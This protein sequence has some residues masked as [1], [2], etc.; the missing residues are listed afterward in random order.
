MSGRAWQ[1]EVVV[2]FDDWLYVLKGLLDR[3]GCGCEGMGHMQVMTECF[4]CWCHS[5]GWGEQW[6]MTLRAGWCSRGG[7]SRVPFGWLRPYP[8]AN[9]KSLKGSEQ[10]SDR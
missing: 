5:V 1:E 3:D 6:E 2:E 9:G 10:S 4:I 8:R 7:G